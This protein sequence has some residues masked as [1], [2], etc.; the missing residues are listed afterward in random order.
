MLAARLMRMT[1]EYVCHVL[2]FPGLALK[3]IWLVIAQFF[4]LITQLDQCVFLFSF[5]NKMV[6]D[7]AWFDIHRA[8]LKAIH[9]VIHKF[10]HRA[11]HRAMH[12]AI[13]RACTELFMDPYIAL[14]VEACIE[15]YIDPISNASRACYCVNNEVYC[16][17][18]YLWW[19]FCLFIILLWYYI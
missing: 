2:V 18:C 7:G 10:I 1:A 6:S 16:F 12:N 14:S 4:F 5:N 9:R 15:L 13:H 11:V 8:V 3:I 19:F 17:C